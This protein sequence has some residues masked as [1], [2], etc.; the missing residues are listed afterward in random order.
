MRDRRVP[1]SRYSRVVGE[2]H[3]VCTDI[4]LEYGRKIYT[5]K[6]TTKGTYRCIK[7][8]FSLTNRTETD[9]ESPQ[10]FPFVVKLYYSLV[11]LYTFCHV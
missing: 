9:T 3:T 4:D 7:S 8:M 2:T 11:S 6:S 10:P 1:K 5:C